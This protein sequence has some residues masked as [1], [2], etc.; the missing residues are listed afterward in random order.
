MLYIHTSVQRIWYTGEK[1]KNITFFKDT[2]T[3]NEEEPSDYS[4]VSKKPQLVAERIF[5]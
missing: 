4:E 1:E 3:E 2:N 5:S